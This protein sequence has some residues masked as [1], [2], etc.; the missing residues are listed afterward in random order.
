MVGRKRRSLN[1]QPPGGSAAVSFPPACRTG[2]MALAR[3]C[4]DLRASAVTALFL[5]SF[6]EIGGDDGARALAAALEQNR[7]LVTLFLGVRLLQWQRSER[8]TD[9][10]GAAQ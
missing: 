6:G 8:G 10:P 4:A 9:A 5:N 3:A 1:G 7:S 2:A